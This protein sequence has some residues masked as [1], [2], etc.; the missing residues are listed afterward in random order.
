MF[1]IGSYDITDNTGARIMTYRASIEGWSTKLFGRY[2]IATVSKFI[3]FADF[4]LDYFSG[5]SSEPK[6]I[7]G[8]YYFSGYSFRQM[9]AGLNSG[10]I[11]FPVKSLGIEGSINIVSF[12]ALNFWSRETGNPLREALGVSLLGSIRIF[13]G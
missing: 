6:S 9:G 13:V 10:I 1:P 8:S 3:A 4:T 2:L 5:K 7:N 12:S 11:F